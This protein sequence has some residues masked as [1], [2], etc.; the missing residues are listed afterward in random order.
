MVSDCCTLM[1]KMLMES[2]GI[3]VEQIETG[4]AVILVR[5]PGTDLKKAG[6]L[7]ASAGMG[8]IKTRDEVISDNIKLAVIDLIHQIGRASCRE[9]V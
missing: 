2:A 8:I 3:L 9:R 1:A 5:D 4:K 7:L 6:Q